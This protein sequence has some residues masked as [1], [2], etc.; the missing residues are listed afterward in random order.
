MFE[1]ELR[2]QSLFVSKDL[3]IRVNTA[4]DGGQ[5]GVAPVLAPV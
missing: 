5:A 3:A 4:K 1:A 2:S